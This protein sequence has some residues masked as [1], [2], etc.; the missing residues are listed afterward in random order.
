MFPA[1]SEPVVIIAYQGTLLWQTA[2]L[3]SAEDTSPT[4]VLISSIDRVSLFTKV[5]LPVLKA[6]ISHLSAEENDDFLIMKII[7]LHRVQYN[8]DC[9]I[10]G[11]NTYQVKMKR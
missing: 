2:E 5:V 8:L 11:E 6:G 4:A 1:F 3:D 9:L 7:F 10:R